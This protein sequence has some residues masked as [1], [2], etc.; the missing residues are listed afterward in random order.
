[1]GS[2]HLGPQNKLLAT[3]SHICGPKKG[4]KPYPPKQIKK[5]PLNA[6]KSLKP[7][8]EE[9]LPFKVSK[10]EAVVVNASTNNNGDAQKWR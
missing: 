8:L 9:T 3:R 6:R 7:F 1:M 10:G 5:G 4:W 2:P